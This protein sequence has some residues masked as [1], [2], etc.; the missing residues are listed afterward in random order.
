MIMA[1]CVMTIG[2]IMLQ[3]LCVK[4]W[5]GRWGEEEGRKGEEELRRGGGGEREG[6]KRER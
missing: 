5:Y 6:G 4:V 1:Q 2:M 3:Q